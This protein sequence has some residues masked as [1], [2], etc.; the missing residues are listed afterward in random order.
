MM[1]FE[2][3]VEYRKDSGKGASRRLRRETDSTPS[4]VP[5]V[6]YGGSEQPVSVSLDHKKLL[7]ALEHEGFYN[8]ILNLHFPDKTQQVV[9]KAL[10]RH[11]FKR[12]ILHV[13]FLRV[14]ATDVITMRVPIHFVGE[15]KAPGVK[16]GG[17]ISHHMTDLEVKCQVQ[18]LP[19]FLT[20]DV[21]H[22]G[23]N[24]VLHISHLKFPT[25]VEPVALLHG[26]GHDLPVVGIHPARVADDTDSAAAPVASAVPATAQK[27]PVQA[28]AAPSPAKDKKSK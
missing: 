23:L 9:L 13:D 25:H 7:R 24:D 10:Q 16:Q 26:E 8:H 14:S 19:E 15:E 18:H 28:P 6:V 2:L 22:M 27:N 1:P 4:Q 17:L 20:V 21:S 5:A 3:A 11:P 12:A